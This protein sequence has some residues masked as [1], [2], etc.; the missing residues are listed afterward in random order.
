MNAIP[1][2]IPTTRVIAKAWKIGNWY[3]SFA[4]V[5]V[6]ELKTRTLQTTRSHHGN[7]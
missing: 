5:K 3:I 6:W 1:R 4:F 2:N 7:Q